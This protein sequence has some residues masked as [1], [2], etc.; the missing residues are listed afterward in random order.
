MIDKEESITPALNRMTD[1]IFKNLHYDSSVST[2]SQEEDS[3]V[4]EFAYSVCK[5]AMNDIISQYS[6]SIVTQP[7]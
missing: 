3:N 1:R 4:S 5:R 7:L 2:S 6:L